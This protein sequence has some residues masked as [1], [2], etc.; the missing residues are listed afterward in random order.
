[1]KKAIVAVI[2]LLAIGTVTFLSIGREDLQSA[3][4]PISGMSC[5]NCADHIETE[6]QAIDGVQKA[7]VSFTE[8]VAKV[9]Y[10]AILT[11]VPVIEKKISGLGY[12]TPHAE[13]TK[14]P[15]DANPHCS[16]S[17]SDTP[18]CCGIKSPKSNT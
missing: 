10:D 12:R 4:I 1:M 15:A 11:T 14:S 5:E 6:L 3:V 9:K 18:D 17:T 8:A 7:E 13:T 16:P 2:V